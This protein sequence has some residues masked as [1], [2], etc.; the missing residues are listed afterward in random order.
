MKK[1]LVYIVVLLAVIGCSEKSKNYKITANVEKIIITTNPHYQT[2]TYIISF[3]NN[4]DK[5]IIL[6]ANSF[7]K[8]E[9][10]KACG[11]MLKTNVL[12]T[13][14]GAM[15]SI[16]NKISIKSKST[17]KYLFAYSNKYP[18]KWKKINDSNVKQE[19][20]KLAKSAS[21]Y[22]SYDKTAIANS[23]NVSELKESI[24]F[25]KDFPVRM[26]NIQIEYKDQ[27][28]LEEAMKLVGGKIEIK[29]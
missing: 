8:D 9:T 1:I 27:I 13:P 15:I 11:I 29:K 25:D 23:Y 26:N 18:N 3:N 28:T 12:T 5:N 17:E 7:V 22:Y 2:L 19:L 16:E 6:F 24:V 4:S 10:Y 20:T 14:I 21:L